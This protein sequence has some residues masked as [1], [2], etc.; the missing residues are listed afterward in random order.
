MSEKRAALSTLNVAKKRNHPED[1][2]NDPPRKAMKLG[3]DSIDWLDGLVKN[4]PIYTGPAM[5]LVTDDEKKMFKLTDELKGL[6]KENR[7]LE[8][9]V[10]RLNNA[11]HD[12]KIERMCEDKGHEMLRSEWREGRLN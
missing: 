11:V 5:R 1:L 8:N 10:Q 9:E 12:Q 2:N 6:R 7:K 3:E 4:T